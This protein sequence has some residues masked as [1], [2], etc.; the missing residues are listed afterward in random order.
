MENWDWESAL[1][2][3][4]GVFAIGLIKYN[5]LI[6]VLFREEFNYERLYV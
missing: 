5:I 2:V 3:L 6:F 1:Y 4:V